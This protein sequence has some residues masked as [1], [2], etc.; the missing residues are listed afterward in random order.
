MAMISKTAKQPM[1]S[2]A[3]AAGVAGAPGGGT[4]AQSSL[5]L[6]IPKTGMSGQ[7]NMMKATEGYI[8]P[9]PRYRHYGYIW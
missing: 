8:N 4:T 9:L 6:R 7:H 2:K 1:A 5:V 3:S